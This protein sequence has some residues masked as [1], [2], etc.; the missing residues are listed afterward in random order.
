MNRNM[1]N[2]SDRIRNSQFVLVF[3]LVT[4]ALFAES[5][6]RAYYDYITSYNGALLLPINFPGD[7]LFAFSIAIAPQLL[8][9]FGFFAM[10]FMADEDDEWLTAMRTWV[11]VITIVSVALDIFTGMIFYAP[12]DGGWAGWLTAFAIA[13]VMDTLFSE[14][15]GAATFGFMTTLLPDFNRE[16]RALLS[17]LANL[18]RSDRRNRGGGGVSRG[19]GRGDSGA[20]DAGRDRFANRRGAQGDGG[21]DPRYTGAAQRPP[22]DLDAVAEHRPPNRHG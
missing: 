12:V 6:V 17:N 8:S 5:M 15:M 21:R 19:G 10:L 22:V 4:V 1:R 18:F 14:V 13:A 11:A 20:R 2:L 3:Y 7:R 9:I 16:G